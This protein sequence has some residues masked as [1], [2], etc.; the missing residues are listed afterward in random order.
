MIPEQKSLRPHDV[1]VLLQI[2]LD[3][4]PTFRDLARLVGL[5][6]GGR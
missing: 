1:C 2:S 5:S 6:L 4:E 3:P